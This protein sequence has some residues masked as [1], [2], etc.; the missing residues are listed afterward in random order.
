MVDEVLKYS[1]RIEFGEQCFEVSH[2]V[3]AQSRREVELRHAIRGLQA[4]LDEEKRTMQMKE[5]ALGDEFRGTAALLSSRDL[6]VNE[7]SQRMM[8]NSM[9]FG[10]FMS[11]NARK[12]NQI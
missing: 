4:E 11:E 8:L 12:T 7:K 3:D 9:W 6:E 10:R 5:D 1:M 2:L